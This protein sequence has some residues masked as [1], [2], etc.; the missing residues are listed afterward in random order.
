MLLR[1]CLWDWLTDHV[2][3]FFGSCQWLSLHSVFLVTFKY[4]QSSLYLPGFSFGILY[5]AWNVTSISHYF[6]LKTNPSWCHSCVVNVFQVFIVLFQV[7]SWKGFSIML[8]K[9][10][11]PRKLLMCSSHLLFCWPVPPPLCGLLLLISETVFLIVCSCSI[12]NN[13]LAW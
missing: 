11:Q 10:M 8:T 12:K 5:L 3:S 2:L 13:G 4:P 1:D 6:T 7:L 9:N